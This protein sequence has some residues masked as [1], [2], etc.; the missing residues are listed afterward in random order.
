MSFPGI[1]GHRPGC[2]KPQSSISSLP[3]DPAMPTGTGRPMISSPVST[4]FIPKAHIVP[5]SKPWPQQTLQGPA[6]I[7]NDVKLIQSQK[8]LT[9]NDEAI[10]EY[11]SQKLAQAEA[12]DT[13]GY[14][15][16]SEIIEKNTQDPAYW[17][18]QPPNRMIL[19]RRRPRGYNRYGFKVLVS[20]EY[21]RVVVNA[22][23][24]RK[25]TYKLLKKD[26]PECPF[27]KT[28]CGH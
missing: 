21:T 20:S 26:P 23:S 16:P 11:H 2:T 17:V 6:Q 24:E 28:V 19:T 14:Q 3:K 12:A 27:P 9:R 13:G 25:Y 10:A 8:A 7:N 5:R 1:P 4:D 22:D 15:Q 18:L